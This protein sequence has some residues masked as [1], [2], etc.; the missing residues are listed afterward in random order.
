MEI[1]LVRVRTRLSASI[2][3]YFDFRILIAIGMIST[4]FYDVRPLRNER[5]FGFDS[6]FRQTPVR[7]NGWREEILRVLSVDLNVWL[8][9]F[10]TNP[11]R[12]TTH[13][14]PSLD[15]VRVSLLSIIR[16]LTAAQL[17]HHVGFHV[18]SRVERTRYFVSVTKAFKT[19]ISDDNANDV[20]L[21]F[22]KRLA[23]DFVRSS[24]VCHGIFV[25][26]FCPVA[27]TCVRV[28]RG[29]L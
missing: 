14:L 23:R 3:D 26:G 13:S 12:T 11:N 5:N 27:R 4:I 15:A 7:A 8:L 19:E 20:S 28:R 6:I 22:P 21:A 1:S 24:R 25:L 17:F 16:L 18:G 9:G 2:E 10:R 29:R